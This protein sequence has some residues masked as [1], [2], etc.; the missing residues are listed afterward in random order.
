MLQCEQ[1][2]T[3]KRPAC[4]SCTVVTGN[5]FTN[6][7]QTLTVYWVAQSLVSTMF[8]QTLPLPMWLFK[9][10]SCQWRTRWI[11]ATWLLGLKSLRELSDVYR[12]VTQVLILNNRICD[13]VIIKSDISWILA[14]K[15]RLD[16]VLH[17]AWMSPK[18]KTN[19][20]S[21]DLSMESIRST[22]NVLILF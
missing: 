13:S 11:H 20:L 15:V 14:I 18:I 5:I 4:N 2:M 22:Q 8:V 17:A 3:L 12:R 10:V 19:I 7:V 21:A 6:Q 1:F 16:A 9:R